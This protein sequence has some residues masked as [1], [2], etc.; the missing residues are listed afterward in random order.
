MSDHSTTKQA[1]DLRPEM[2]IL[3]PATLV[4]LAIAIPSILWPES[5]Q[6]L[7]KTVNSSFTS[8]FGSLYL[9]VSFIMVSLSL[10]FVF[11][12]IG[13]IKF[14]KPDEKPEFGN[15]GWLAMMFCTGVAG[16]VMFWSVV[17]PLWDLLYPPQYAP[18]MSTGAYEWSL[19]YVFFH[20]G[21]LCWPW[22]VITALP[23]CYMFY[24]LKKPVLRISAAAEP[25]LG[26]KNVNGPVGAIIETFFVV[27]LVFTNA[28]IMAISIPIVNHAIASTMGVAPSKSM[29]FGVIVVSSIIFCGSLWMGLKKGIQRLSNLNVII[30]LSMVGFA[31][32]FGPTQF[33]LDTA[34]NS[35]GV[36]MDN[37]FKMQFWTDPFTEGRFPQDWTI[38][39]ALWMASYGPVMG[40]FIARISR[41]R[42]VRQ[43]IAM[44]VIGGSAGSFLIH[45]VFGS[46]T[47]H[48]Q[49][50]GIVDAVAILKESGGPAAMVAVLQSLPMGIVVLVGYCIF[51][52]IFLAT[53]VDSCS[54]V[55]ST[56]VTKKLNPSEDP[57]RGHRLYWAL[58]QA[59][60]A[61]ALLM[62]G[63]LGSAKVFGIFAGALMVFPIIL[64]VISWFIM[65]R[66]EKSLY[67]K[68]ESPSFPV[69]DNLAL[70]K[71]AVE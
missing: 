4:I 44:G 43:I 11:S 63:G 31:F 62:L 29:E 64:V 53:S 71:E 25:L 5:S 30:A 2:R 37:Y 67:E 16:A 21:P 59:G 66:N 68:S 49:M 6:K 58:L 41:G 45:G 26:K 24:K 9:W 36:M 54:L 50:N 27:G 12:K 33:M 19:A 34:T 1:S 8:N 17:E 55:I 14:G 35:F 65:L 10:Y 70:A 40:L 18:A 56:A 42:T 46:Y 7:F 69:T 57:S 47:L 13:D 32:I 60:L 48:A 3:I 22:Y 52:T 61:V 51:S 39:Y 15:F 38:F 23:I 28:V 20:W